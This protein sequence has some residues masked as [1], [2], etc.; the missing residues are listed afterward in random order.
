MNL[1]ENVIHDLQKIMENIHQICELTSVQIIGFTSA[2][3]NQGTSSVVT[4]LSLLMAARE[5]LSYENVD[6]QLSGKNGG[7][8]KNAIRHGVLLMDGQL[9]HPSLHNKFG[10]AQS[11]GILEVLEN[12]LSTN[13]LIKK[14]D[15]SALKIVTTGVSNNFNLAQS[16]IEKLYTMLSNARKRVRFIFIDIPPILAYSEGI[17]LSH[18]CDG[19]VLIMQAGEIRWEVVQETRRLL[20]RAGVQIIGG[21]LNRREYF[22]PNWI[23]NNI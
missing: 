19:V 3:P 16:H 22:I 12:E 14:I 23:Y 4:L 2:I 6:E 10:L 11:G 15:S 5:K 17:S 7:N 9:R 21:I 18:L 13:G 20:E 8:G 1:P